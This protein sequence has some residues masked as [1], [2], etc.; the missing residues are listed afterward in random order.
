MRHKRLIIKHFISEPIT[1]GFDIPPALSKKPPCP[2]AFQWQGKNYRVTNCL[3]EWQDFSR[4][5]RSAQN[6]QPQHAKIASQ[7]GSWGVGKYFFDVR[8]KLGSLYRI[9]FDRAPKDAYDREGHWFLLAELY[10]LES[11]DPST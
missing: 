6:M 7:R 1:V 4:Q 3:S 9:Y 2:N 10:E 8:V 5:G 11:P